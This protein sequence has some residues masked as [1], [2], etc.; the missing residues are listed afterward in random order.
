MLLELNNNIATIKDTTLEE[1]RQFMVMANVTTIDSVVIN[2]AKEE[3]NETPQP[4]KMSFEVD[5]KPIEADEESEVDECKVIE[6]PLGFCPRRY[7]KEYKEK[8]IEDIKK[9]KPLNDIAYKYDIS[10]NTLYTWKRR[11]LGYKSKRG[12]KLS[13]DISDYDNW[14]KDIYEYIESNK[15]DIKQTFFKV[16][17]ELTKV[18]G[19]NFEQLGKDFKNKYNRK[20]MSTIELIY[21]WQYEYEHGEDE[22][23]D[24]LFENLV[25]DNMIKKGA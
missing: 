21:F 25:M 14:R 19:L 11:Y 20:A 6:K 16:Y 3:V 24:K 9:G 7:T 12:K 18:Y 22:R 2:M 17:R 8:I 13:A 4:I 23:W 15:G 1:L 5:V 10:Y